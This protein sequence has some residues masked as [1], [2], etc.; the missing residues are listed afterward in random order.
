MIFENVFRNGHWWGAMLE[1]TVDRAVGRSAEDQWVQPADSV[2][3]EA[4]W[5]CGRTHHQMVDSS[6]FW[7]AP[8][9]PNNEVNPCTVFPGGV[10]PLNAKRNAETVRNKQVTSA[11]EQNLPGCTGP[12]TDALT[13]KAKQEAAALQVNPWER[14][15]TPSPQIQNPPRD[16]G[17]PIGSLLA[18]RHINTLCPRT[19]LPF[20]SGLCFLACWLPQ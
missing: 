12:S 3:M 13:L 6:S 1:L 16:V 9:D 10:S 20:T 2:R 15:I 8:W 4:V 11:L 19:P 14:L 5:V 7:V 18:W 17:G